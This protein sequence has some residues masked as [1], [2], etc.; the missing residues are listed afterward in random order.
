M[1]PNFTITS[2]QLVSSAFKKEGI[3]DFIQ[4]TNYIQN[5]PYKRNTNKE[6]V[7]CVLSDFGGT[8]STKH[9]ILKILADENN[10]PEI[11]LKL[12]IFRMNAN[13]TPKI[14]EVLKKY[15]ILEMPEA[16]NYL[17]L[18]ELRFDYTRTNSKPKN[19]EDD[20]LEEIT[21]LPDQITDFKVQYHRNFIEKYLKQNPKIPYNLEEFWQIREECIAALQQ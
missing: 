14:K 5:L 17:S 16:H 8:C 7:L 10:H 9:A 11:V 13:N 18:N 6:E 15:S 19:F 4:A 21:I 3:F 1:L 12:G 2:S 20:L